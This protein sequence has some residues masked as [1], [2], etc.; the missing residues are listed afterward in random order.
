MRKQSLQLDNL[1][2]VLGAAKNAAQKGTQQFETPLPMARALMR[3]LTGFRGV[4][5][6]LTCGHGNLLAA[7]SNDTTRHVV[8]VD[9]DP[10]ATA[11]PHGVNLDPRP[12]PHCLH[13]D[14]NTVVPLLRDVSW[15][16]DLI[17]LNPPFSLQWADG[18]SS[19]V[20]WELAQE[21]LTTN[22]EGMMI[23]A[24]TIVD[25]ILA[26]AYAHRVWLKLTAP[27]FFPGVRLDSVTVLYFAADHSAPLRKGDDGSPMPW[28]EYTLPSADPLRAAEALT[29]FGRNRSRWINGATVNNG[30]AAQPDTA[31]AF[32][33]VA[34]EWRRRHD[35]KMQAR[36]GWNIRLDA[37]GRINAWLTPFQKITGTIPRVFAEELQ[38]LHGQF[39]LSLVVQ[40]ATREALQRAVNGTIWRVQPE[41]VTAVADAVREYHRVRAPFTKLPPV[42]RLAYLDEENTIVAATS[43]LKGFTKGQS[44]PL[45]TLTFEGKK[46]EVRERPGACDEDVLVTGMELAVLITD[47]AG[48]THCFTQFAAKEDDG[49]PDAQHHHLLSALVNH[50]VIPEVPDVATLFPDL[51]QTYRERLLALEPIASK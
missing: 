32:T 12:K 1:G 10:T 31:E 34:E 19:M 3:P 11:L 39:P 44:Y 7:A 5:T 29:Q 48:E 4:I 36:Q 27:N 38:S 2:A 17:V 41:L 18:D 24:G 26:G 45:A 25:R 33:A 47:D 43:R 40:R 8:G 42:M 9:L 6:D 50:F 30:Y 46:V 23:C 28:I 15:K 51:Y 37:D 22:G 16:A 20:C 14:L 13:A 35:A 21:F 49:R